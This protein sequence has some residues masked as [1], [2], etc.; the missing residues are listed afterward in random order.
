ML[1]LIKQVSIVLLRLSFSEF[2]VTKCVS[3]NDELC[4]VRPTHIDLN[5]TFTISLDKCNESCNVLSPKVCVLKKKT[6]MYIMIKNEIFKMIT[7]S[8]EAKTVTKHISCDFKCRFNSAT[9][10]SNQK[11]NNKT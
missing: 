9:C 4:L 5:P 10:N 11:W 7:N 2:L 8:N 3:L 6:Q 1:S